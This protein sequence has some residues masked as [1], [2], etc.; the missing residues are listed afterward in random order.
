MSATPA[1]APAVASSSEGP[2]GKDSS[3]TRSYSAESVNV[4]SS[5]LSGLIRIQKVAKKEH[6]WITEDEIEIKKQKPK[7]GQMSLVWQA[8]WRSLNIAVKT[9][10]ETS[11]KHYLFNKDFE[12]LM[13]EIAVWKTL[14]H[15]RI[16]MFLGASFRKDMG[17]MLLLENMQGG[18]LEDYL[19][20]RKKINSRESWRIAQDISQAMAFLHSCKPPLI[21]GDLKPQNVLF[22]SFGQAKVSDF[23]LSKFATSHSSPTNLVK[24][25]RYIAPEVLLFRNTTLKSDVYSYGIIVVE[26]FS[27]GLNVKMDN[28]ISIEMQKAKSREEVDISFIQSK[29]PREIAARCVGLEPENRTTF[30]EIIE[31]LD[32]N[33]QTGC[34]CVVC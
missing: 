17:V 3:L 29:V 9:V 18:T 33:K 11:K 23:G 5:I 27:M 8:E 13:R 24:G 22:N 30:Q 20:N 2:D 4:G 14:R 19:D 28:S 15:P 10:K 32:E 21:H 12:E 25:A 1:L 7:Q 31:I 26:L 16:V 34:Q 6:W